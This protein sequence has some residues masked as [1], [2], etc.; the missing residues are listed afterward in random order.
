MVPGRHETLIVNED[1]NWKILEIGDS[2]SAW[3]RTGASE[4][5]GVY[6]VKDK[7]WQMKAG[8]ISALLSRHQSVQNASEENASM[9]TQNN[10]P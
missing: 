6:A 5:I 9:D 1:S 2:F 7:G 3:I 4:T 10:D 8:D